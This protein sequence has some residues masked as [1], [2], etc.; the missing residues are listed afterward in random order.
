MECATEVVVTLLAIAVPI[1]DQR[2]RP[3]GIFKCDSYKA[4]AKQRGQKTL[5]GVEH[6]GPR[7]PEGLVD[8]PSSAHVCAETGD[9]AQLRAISRAECN[10]PKSGPVPPVNG[11]TDHA[12]RPVPERHVHPAE[13]GSIHRRDRWGRGR[14]G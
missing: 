14:A 10:T 7:A 11:W 2:A 13:S 6:R 4:A 8:S 5:D 12:A 3:Q 1:A 9:I